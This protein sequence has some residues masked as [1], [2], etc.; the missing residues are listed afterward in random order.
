[1]TCYIARAGRFADA[2][3]VSVRGGSCS[4]FALL[5]AAKRLTSRF[6]SKTG[7]DV[8]LIMASTPASRGVARSSKSA[9]LGNGGSRSCRVWLR[10]T[11]T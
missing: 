6:S 7:A 10:P 5:D 11:E 3:T 4:R 8:Y 1:M 2:S 9:A